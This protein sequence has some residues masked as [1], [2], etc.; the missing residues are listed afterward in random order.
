ML[1]PSER[2]TLLK[3]ISRRL[4]GEDWPLIDIT[5]S[6]FKLPISETWQ[7]GDKEAYVLSM[8]KDAR[9]QA[10]VDLGQHVGFQFDNMPKPGI[11]PPFWRKGMFRI[12][13]SIYPQ[14]RFLL[15]NFKKPFLTLVSHR[16]LPTVI[17]NL[18]LSGKDKLKLLFQPQIHLWR[19]YIQTSTQ[20]TGLIKKSVSLWGG[21][22][23]YLQCALVKILMALSVVSKHLQVKTNCHLRYAANS[24]MPIK[25]INKPSKRWPKF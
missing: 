20:A 18:H 23:P 24:S 10:L 13:L 21:A 15:Q 6:Q 9:D 22:F 2:I 3:E 25:L 19:F 7:S 1:T 11:D 12:F 17:L 8:A 4:S 16:S 14:K 5:L